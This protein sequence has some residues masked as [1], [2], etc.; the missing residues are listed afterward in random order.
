MVGLHRFLLLIL[1]LL[2]STTVAAKKLYKYQDPQGRWYFSDQPP[3][4]SQPVE[5]RQLKPAPK[6]RVKLEKTGT[7]SNPEFYLDNQY[8]GPIEVEI[9]WRERDSVV[10]NPELPQRFVVEQGKS[11]ILFSVKGEG[12]GQSSSRRFSLQYSYV[13]GRPLSTYVGSVAYVPPLEAGNR[14]LITQAFEGEFSHQDLQNRYAVDIKMPI[15]TPIHAAR[16][17][18]IL[19]VENDF[20]VGGTQ[21]AYINKANSIRILHDDGSMAIYAHLALE[22]AQVYPGLH[23]KA[24]DL[25]AYSGNTGFS[26]G[27]HLHFAVQVNRGMELVS[28]PF[29][30]IDAAQQAFEPRLGVWLEG[31]KPQP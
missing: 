29:Q 8:P 28:V 22:K 21:Q 20:F 27:P 13:V 30:F 25:I 24:G 11:E 14:F 10:A 17:G 12:V 3:V 18:V 5:V 19:E 26:S 1:L 15:G 6:R 7:N 4:T 2:L 16:A 23:V 31:I 9:E